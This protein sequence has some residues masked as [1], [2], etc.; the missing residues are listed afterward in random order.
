MQIMQQPS[1]NYSTMLN[2]SFENIYDTYSPMLFGI[3]VQISP[4]EKEAEVIIIATF[5]KIHEQN[6][7][8]Q[9]SPLLCVTLIKLLIQTAHEQLKL[10]NFKLKQFENAPLLH[11]L[12]CEQAELENHCIE[13]NLSRADARKILHEEFKRLK[14]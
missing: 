10:K 14:N 6:L 12:L 2:K 1:K 11:K 13:N 3:A 8:D 7:I 5:K 4:T 9:T